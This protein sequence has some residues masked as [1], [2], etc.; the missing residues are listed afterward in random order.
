MADG[1]FLLEVDRLLRPGGYFVWTSQMNTHRS[2]RDKENQKKWSMIHDFAEN[3]CWDILSQQD[4][5]I[6]WKKTSKKKCYTSRYQTLVHILSC[7]ISHI[8][9]PQGQANCDPLYS[10][11]FYYPNY[12]H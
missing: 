4:E 10:N 12:M 8:M 3:L 11:I 1:I 6:V 5:T 9:I 2:L 7:Y